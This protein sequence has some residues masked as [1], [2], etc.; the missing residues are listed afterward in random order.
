MTVTGFYIG[1]GCNISVDELPDILG[2][3]SNSFNDKT[4]NKPSNI[5]DYNLKSSYQ[6]KTNSNNDN[7]S[8]NESDSDDENKN[9]NNSD[10]SN[11][12][13]DSDPFLEEYS[14]DKNENKNYN[15]DILSAIDQYLNKYPIIMSN[16]KDI[17][18]MISYPHSHNEYKKNIVAIGIFVH[19]GQFNSDDTESKLQKIMCDGILKK[20][21]KNK[22]GKVP[23]FMTI[24]NDC[25]CCS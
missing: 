20:K 4:K 1:Y 14:F 11:S 12:D 23:K 24:A 2:L 19:V 5:L 7:E 25:N 9:D 10:S 6:W 16:N 13:S 8:D 15:Y 3:N 17:V 22:F 18:K 21:F